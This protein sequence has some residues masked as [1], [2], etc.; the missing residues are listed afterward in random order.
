MNF[1]T[2]STCAGAISEVSR[3]SEG[4]A[5]ESLP[6]RL[7]RLTFPAKRQPAFIA[8]LIALTWLLLASTH[9]FSQGSSGFVFAS[10]P[11]LSD[12]RAVMEK[13]QAAG[14]EFQKRDEDGDLVFRGVVL[15]TKSVAYAFLGSKR[16]VKVQVVMATP[17]SEARRTYD[18]MRQVLIEKYGKPEKTY[19]FFMTPYYEG[20]GFENQAIRVGKGRFASFWNK[21][22]DGSSLAI[23]ISERLA[24][25]VEYE[26]P[27]YGVELKRRRAA[28]T[29][30][31]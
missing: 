12:E 2:A 5:S 18:E 24:V 1:I 15:G 3:G 30:A 6:I 7:P 13:M 10:I 25:S 26:S 11:W 20:D 22:A 28:G 14:F 21:A 29:T 27:Q 9:A 23:Y 16:L 19:A 17:D 31:F 4:K 8:R